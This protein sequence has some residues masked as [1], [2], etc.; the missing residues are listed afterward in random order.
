M[1]SLPPQKPLARRQQVYWG[2]SCPNGLPPP[3]RLVIHSSIVLSSTVAQLSLQGSTWWLCLHIT[4]ARC[5]IS[6]AAHLTLWS[7]LHTLV[8]RSRGPAAMPIEITESSC[9]VVR[10]M[11]H[12]M[13][14]EETEEGRMKGGHV[15]RAFHWVVS[16]AT[17]GRPRAAPP[18]C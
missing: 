15:R 6:T 14:L 5:A 4:C 1:R 13:S 17:G 3:S 9:E 16:S 2:C 10:R 11:K 18:T 7:R 12:T 8:P